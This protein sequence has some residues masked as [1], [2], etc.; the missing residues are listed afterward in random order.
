MYR[1][2]Y[3][4]GMTHRAIDVTVNSSRF[5]I[6][7]SLLQINHR[8][9]T[10]RFGHTPPQVRLGLEHL[11]VTPLAMIHGATISTTIHYSNLLLLLWLRLSRCTAPSLTVPYPLSLHYA[12]P[13]MLYRQPDSSMVRALAISA[14]PMASFDRCS[15]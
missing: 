1:S 3:S 11:T 2:G 13:D 5:S 14:R 4:T 15:I 10:C 12:F 9:D 8:H 7:S 6:L